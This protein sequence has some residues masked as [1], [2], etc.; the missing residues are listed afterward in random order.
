MM[1]ANDTRAHSFSHLI[2]SLPL[3]YRHKGQAGP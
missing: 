3:R 1:V 2:V